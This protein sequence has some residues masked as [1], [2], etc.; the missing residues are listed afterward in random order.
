MKPKPTYTN[1]PQTWRHI[2]VAT[3]E[4]AIDD[5]RAAMAAGALRRNWTHNRRVIPP[6]S[7]AGQE[8]PLL[9][10]WFHSE[11]LGCLLKFAGVRI[12]AAELRQKISTCFA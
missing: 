2:A 11:E 6:K 10:Q 9:I 1:D 8:V 3:I 12:T 5:A 4:Q 7:L